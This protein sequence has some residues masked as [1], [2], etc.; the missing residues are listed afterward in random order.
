[1]S[2]RTYEWDI[3]LAHAGADEASAEAL[4]DL[5]SESAK[6]FLDTRSLELGDEWDR[7]LPRA[8][9]RSGR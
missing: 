1:M 2:S 9:S 4:Y 5:L 6:V 7:A 8:Q 3:F